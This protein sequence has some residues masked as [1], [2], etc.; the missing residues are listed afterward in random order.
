MAKREQ[1]LLKRRQAAED[2]LQQSAQQLLQREQLLSPEEDSMESIVSHG[3]QTYPQSLAKKQTEGKNIPHSNKELVQNGAR[4]YD[5]SIA[6]D[7]VSPTKQSPLPATTHTPSMDRTLLANRS[8]N[9]EQTPTSPSIPEVLSNEYLANQSFENKSDKSSRTLSEY[10]QDTF[11]PEDASSSITQ[12]ALQPS[13]LATTSVSSRRTPGGYD[14]EQEEENEDSVTT[15]S[16]VM[17]GKKEGGG[18]KGRS[19]Q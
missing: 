6:K 13:P 9:S 19:G 18:G 10:V 7:I 8:L 11:E 4:I 2:E 12:S 14:L 15:L 3:L 16:E 5:M 17:S 1:R